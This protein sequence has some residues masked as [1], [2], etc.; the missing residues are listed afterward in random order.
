VSR[1][2]R[3][4]EQALLEAVAGTE[5]ASEVE[6][7]IDKPTGIGSPAYFGR[8]LQR[9]RLHYEASQED[10]AARLGLNASVFSRLERGE[11]PVPKRGELLAW[12]R[13]LPILPEEHDDLVLAAGYIPETDF[14]DRSLT[15]M[16]RQ[17]FVG[18]MRELLKKSEPGDAAGK[19]GKLI[20]NFRALPAFAKTRISGPELDD[21]SP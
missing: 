1:V 16:E 11:H 18:A 5:L 8:C 19:F 4:T 13:L 14:E 9:L 2:R 6:A 15:S 7:L 20:N 21:A 10:W 12:S 3:T 17:V